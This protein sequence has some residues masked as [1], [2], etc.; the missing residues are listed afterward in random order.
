[1]ALSDVKSVILIFS[2]SDYGWVDKLTAYIKCKFL[3]EGGGGGGRV[4][5][6][7]HDMGMYHYFGYLFGVLPDFWVSVWI[8]PRF[9]GII[10]G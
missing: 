2:C 1:M 7:C 3:G 5:C 8:A 6:I 10:F 9:L 4:T